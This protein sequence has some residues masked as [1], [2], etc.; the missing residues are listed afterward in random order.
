M[1]PL[2]AVVS[3]T[4]A[5]TGDF[6]AWGDVEVQA[7]P[8]RNLSVLPLATADVAADG[9]FSLELPDGTEEV[10]LTL[11]PKQGGTIPLL[12]RELPIPVPG[13]IEI[14][15]GAPP[16]ERAARHQLAG[17]STLALGGGALLLLLL[18]V[19]GGRALLARRLTRDL[20]PDRWTPPEIPPGTGGPILWAIAAAVTGLLLYGIFA[21]DE[22]LDLLEY[23]YFQEAFAGDNV[24][25]VAFSPVVAE[26][27]HAPGY[28]VLLHALTSLLRSEWF[29]RLPAAIAVFAGA[30]ALFR[31]T[32]DGTGSKTAGWIA[33]LLGSLTPLAMRYGRDVTP[34]SLVGLLA[35]LST[36]LLYR[37]LVT[38]ER[39]DWAGY[40]AVSV[41]A[42]FL[43]YF[44]AFLVI[45]Q[46]LAGLWLFLR[47]GRGR[48]WTTRLRQALAA[49]GILGALPLL[50]S[51]Q[52][53]RAF[54]I[55][56]QDNL[57]T[58]A[59]YPVAPDFVTY[60][61]NHLAVLMGLPA[62]L[63]L[64]VWPLLLLLVA[65]YVMLLRDH[66]VFGRLLLIPLLMIVGLL[67]TTYGLHK[68]AY[69]GRIY[70]GWRWLR[71]YVA[72]IAV[73][74][75]YLMVVGLPRPARIAALAGGAVLVLATAW[76]GVAS[77]LHFE[78]PAQ[79]AAADLLMS[80]AKDGDVIA[81][82]PAAFYAPG[83]AFYLQG[84]NAKQ[85]HAGPAMW[86]YF[87]DRRGDYKRVYGPVRSF[88]I[89]L[90][91]LIGHSEI[92]RLWV[93]VLREEIFGQPEFDPVLPERAIETLDASMT[94]LK[95]WRM[96]HLDVLLYENHPAFVPEEGLRIDLERLHTALPWLPAALE[97]DHL[98][99]A[100]RGLRPVRVRVP[101][102]WKARV[103]GDA[104]GV[105]MSVEHKRG[106]TNIRLERAEVRP[107]VL[108]VLP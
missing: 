104:K 58:H 9:R 18:I 52:V 54:V 68:W 19:F 75:A 87:P 84:E 26:R 76:S 33:A 105:N 6:A 48:F 59:V 37:A 67:V 22:A 45:G 82:L 65:G 46:A 103:R 38:G 63:S 42:F 107:L 99:E 83:L 88:G 50:W 101:G 12:L 78:R 13:H 74:I 36:W 31:L 44:T 94:R 53:V 61:V 34:Y 97:P 23:T 56:E 35:I 39:R 72:A 24:F 51:A 27:A 62:D 55:S 85:I 16:S 3:L 106:F 17:P 4:G 86:R 92:E 11:W 95:R 25:A 49:F 10:A 77:A 71:P 91:S 81:L 5:L 8:G 96:P 1:L 7:L 108:E 21:L 29:L 93:V 66:P 79:R 32:F 15:V 102:K 28:A 30:F 14:A 100:A 80:N 20:P 69:G 41:I 70:Y 98:I 60:A 73:P 2:F 40:A 89:P 64:A 57:V 43:H 90:E 47:G